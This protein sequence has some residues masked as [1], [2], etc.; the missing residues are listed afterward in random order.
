MYRTLLAPQMRFGPLLQ[1]FCSSCGKILKESSM[2]ELQNEQLKEECPSCGSLLIDTLENRRLSLSAIQQQGAHDTSHKTIEK[3]SVNFQTAHRQIEASNIKLAFDIDRLDSLFNLNT[4][5]SLCIK[6]EQKYA[7][8]LID[9]LCVHSMLPK[10]HGGIGEDYL[11]IISIDAGNCTDV[12]QFV[13]FAR[14]YGLEAKG[15]LQNI[16]VSR[17]FTIYQ[18]A[19]LI[20][21]ELPRIIEQLSS[22]RKSNLIIVYGLLHLFLSDPHIDKKDAKQLI[23]E[24]A[25]SIRKLSED[26]FIVASFADCNGEYEKTLLPVF[27]NMIEIIDDD[28]NRGLLQTKVHNQHFR[29]KDG[30]TGVVLRKAE[31]TL[32][33]AR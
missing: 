1:L 24:I 30:L 2:I 16:I 26:R 9:R 22:D 15:V 25:N 21:Y 33:P 13:N 8:L 10:R 29:R 6:G 19:H 14:Q 28:D 7:Q 5:G 3:I 18:L 32:V 11:K 12:Y 20:I 27:D 31:L 17:V 4:H 23:K